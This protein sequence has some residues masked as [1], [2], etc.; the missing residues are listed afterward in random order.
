MTR[1][2]EEQQTGGQSLRPEF[3]WGV[4]II[5][6]LI[7]TAGVL[8]IS[9]LQQSQ[10]N[11]N[12]APIRSI[13]ANGINALGR[14]EPSGEVIRLSAPAGGLSGASRIEEVMVKEGE[15]VKEGQ[16]IAVLDTFSG[17]QANLDQARSRLKESRASLSR[18]RA[19]IP[20]DLEA[21]K[22]VVQR[23]EA[24]LKGDRITLKANVKRLEA[25]IKGQEKALR[26]SISRLAA[27]ANNAQIDSRRYDHLFR[28]GAISEQERDR[29]QLS[30]QT[31]DEQ[32]NQGIAD[33]RRTL[34][35]LWQ[36]LK[37]ARANQQRTIVSSE[38][39][40]QEERSRLNKLINTSPND[41]KAAE[42]QV[43]NAIA[44]V[45][46]AESDLNLSYVKAPFAGEIIKINTKPGEN[47]STN[48][49][50]EL[51]RTDQ[52]TVIVEIPEDSINRIK[53]GQRARITSDSNAFTGTLEGT[54]SEIGRKVGRR[55]VINNDPAADVDAR[56]VEVTVNL[57][58]E[59][60][61]RVSGLTFARVSVEIETGN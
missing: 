23:L 48:G 2:G 43:S 13:S 28:R 61:E 9:R 1:P 33:R 38:R 22:A 31:S 11:N 34:E 19:S 58:P 4:A 29:R 18:T 10:T 41:I 3:S 60:S 14:L 47:I 57:T 24:Q 50:A 7:I 46:K 44:T 37:E 26:A 32:F 27:E 5:L 15:R 25:E 40:L 39:Q 20:E 42:A 12:P 59:D 52:M 36:Q 54:V 17:N 16:I 49:V 6:P 35:T 30:A 56:V 21:Q 51:G 55:E 8:A 45:Q 53:L